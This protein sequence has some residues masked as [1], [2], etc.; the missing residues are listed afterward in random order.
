MSQSSELGDRLQAAL[1][2]AYEVRD[3]L[4]TGGMATVFLA[5]ERKADLLRGARG[6]PA[7]LSPAR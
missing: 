6:G 4:A 1:G 3:T 2:D 7:R 5:R